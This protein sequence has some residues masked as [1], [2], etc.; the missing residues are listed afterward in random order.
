MNEKDFKFSKRA[1][2]YDEGFEGRFSK[3]FYNTLL[4]NLK[5]KNGYNILDVGC[6]TGY[7]LS[8][9][10][11]MYKINGYGIDAEP[12]MIDI[13]KKKC[14]SMNIRISA[15]ENTPYESGMFDV[16]TACMAYHHFSDKTGFAKEASRILRTGGN[17]YIADPKFPFPIRKVINGILKIHKITG[18]FFTSQEI[19]NDFSLYGFELC[20][21][22][23]DGI[24]QVVKLRKAS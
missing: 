2:A 12:N 15:S 13:A 11:D 23:Y 9:I 24:V 14:H 5:I 6:G 8:K 7:L 1:A 21:T 20:D 22:F 4:L 3:K 17:L 16:L 18:K 10:A 19:V